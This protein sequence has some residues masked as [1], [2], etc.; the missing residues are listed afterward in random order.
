MACFILLLL[1]SS[2][3][4]YWLPFLKAFLPGRV[5]A[6]ILCFPPAHM[7]GFLL[8]YRGGSQGGFQASHD[9]PF[10]LGQASRPLV[11]LHRETRITDSDIREGFNDH[12]KGL[13]P[14]VCGAQGARTSGRKAEGRW[15]SFPFLSA[16]P[17]FTCLRTELPSKILLD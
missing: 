7:S 10:L 13:R 8:Q 16:L 15:S 2:L 9:M 12:C 14:G 11:S 1:T 5:L 4:S 3:I 17:F 6:W